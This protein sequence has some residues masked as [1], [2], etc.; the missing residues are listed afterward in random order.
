MDILQWHSVIFAELCKEN[1]GN[2]AGK[3]ILCCVEVFNI[4]GFNFTATVLKDQNFT[5]SRILHKL[6]SVLA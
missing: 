1:G 3:R 5:L 6:F 2:L 4:L